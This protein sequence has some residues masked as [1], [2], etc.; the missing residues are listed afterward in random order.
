MMRKERQYAKED[1]NVFRQQVRMAA[2]QVTGLR[3][4][5]LAMALAYEVEPFS[6]VPAADAEVAYVPVAD[7]DPAVRV[8]DVTV[9][10]KK[11][12]SAGGCERFLAPAL[13]IGAIALLLA[14]ADF[15]FMQRKLYALRREVAVQTELEARLDAV[16]KPAAAARAEAQAMRERR[17]AAARAQDD[18]ARAR[19]SYAHLLK[20]VAAAYGERAVL[21]SI[22]GGPSSVRIKG[23]A[24]TASA[25]A[26]VQV[27]LTRA[28]AEHGWR[29]VPGQIVLRKP[30]LTAEF[31]SELA[32]D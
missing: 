9:T 20:A 14:A 6:G 32:H 8:Y 22:E 26:D 4:D 12:R 15:F 11:K 17:E 29:L 13:V 16:R 5:E 27:A 19:A 30:G 25:A 31:E 2:V 1:S 3:Q 10:R 23:V 21:T 7:A 18:V 28:A 24:A